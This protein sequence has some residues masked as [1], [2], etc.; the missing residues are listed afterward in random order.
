VDPLSAS[1]PW[2]TPYQFAGNAPIWAIDLDGLEQAIAV[3]FYNANGTCAGVTIISVTNTNDRP[4]GATSFLYLNVASTRQNR[5]AI[6]RLAGRVSRRV[7]V[8][9]A[10]RNFLR[11]NTQGNAG[12]NSL[13]LLTDFAGN[14]ISYMDNMG[15]LIF[16]MAFIRTSFCDSDMATL[17]GINSSV[18]DPGN[19]PT[20]AIF[21][22][23]GLEPDNIYYADESKTYDP[24]LD[25]DNNGKTNAQE[26]QEAENKI[27]GDPDRTAT[28]TGHTSLED[29]PGGT[30]NLTISNDR[31]SVVF[32]ILSEFL[33]T[34]ARVPSAQLTNGGGVGSVEADPAPIQNQD[35]VPSINRKAKITYDI[36]FQ[37]Q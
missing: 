18:Q 34:N 12:S 11:A 2:Y 8:Q 7:P 31:A 1:Y 35:G 24:S 9:N 32:N 21:I 4:L 15:N 19:S 26:L 17:R 13:D 36:P 30:T 20:N 28:V 3:R 29:R 22:A 10:L 16:G 6:D 23:D 5:R 25:N 37:F 27:L 33:R 14:P